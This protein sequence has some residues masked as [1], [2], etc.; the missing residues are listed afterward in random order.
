MKYTEVK[1]TY[2]SCN[3]ISQSGT[4]LDGELALVKSQM[5]NM[6]PRC[7][8]VCRNH[9]LQ[10]VGLQ[11]GIYNQRTRSR[12]LLWRW[13]FL[14]AAATSVATGGCQQTLS[15]I[16]IIVINIQH[17]SHYGNTTYIYT[18]LTV[19]TPELMSVSHFFWDYYFQQ[20]LKHFLLW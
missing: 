9:Q 4:Y 6:I 7:N 18:S 1:D 20:S 5:K 13:E 19:A 10:I 15:T 12:D 17:T 16:C 3:I 2:V 14:V 11:P 8:E